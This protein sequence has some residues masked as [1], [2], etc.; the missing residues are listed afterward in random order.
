MLMGLLFWNVV[1]I[2]SGWKMHR[3]ESHSLIHSSCTHCCAHFSHRFST[4]QSAH[5]NL[6]NG[7]FVVPAPQPD[8]KSATNPLLRLEVGALT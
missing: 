7:Q 6:I 5:G 2:S 3:S 8:T 1:V 4:F